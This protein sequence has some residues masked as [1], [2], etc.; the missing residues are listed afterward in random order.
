MLPWYGRRR[1]ELQ[2]RALIREQAF[3]ESLR[4]DKLEVLVRYE[5]HLD[6]RQERMLTMLAWLK[7]LQAAPETEERANI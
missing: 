7:E 2:N 5:A 1:T 3:G 6:R 4:E